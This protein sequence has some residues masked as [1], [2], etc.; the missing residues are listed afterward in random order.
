MTFHSPTLL[1]RAI[2]LLPRPMER[3]E[4]ALNDECRIA[5]TL[6]PSYVQWRACHFVIIQPEWLTTTEVPL[7]SWLKEANSHEPPDIYRM[8]R[9]QRPWRGNTTRGG[10]EPDDP[11]MLVLRSNETTILPALALPYV[12]SFPATNYTRECLVW[13]NMSATN[14]NQTRVGGLLVHNCTHEGHPSDI[15]GNKE[16]IGSLTDDIPRQDICYERLE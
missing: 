3:R 16:G 1:S 4:R 2:R 9:L 12:P 14:A 15:Q 10:Q 7:W 8:R 11:T 5:C 6:I 13:C